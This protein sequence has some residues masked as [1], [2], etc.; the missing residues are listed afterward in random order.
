[1][2]LLLWVVACVPRHSPGAVCQTVPN[3]S[4][5]VPAHKPG[6]RVGHSL[7]YDDENQ[8]VLLIDGYQPPHTPLR[9]E[10]WAWDGARWRLAATAGPHSR[11]M[12]GVAYDSRRNRLIVYGGIATFSRSRYGDTWEWDG[13]AWQERAV[14]GPGPRDH[15]AMAFDSIRGKTVAYGGELRDGT[16][17]WPTDTWEW[18]GR[19]W[20]SFRAAGPN[21]RAHHAL[22]FDEKRGRVVLFGGLTEDRRYEGDTWEWDGSV[23]KRVATEGPPARTRHQMAFDRRRGVVVLYGGSGVRTKPGDGFN[24]LE[25]TWEW[26][27]R[28]WTE[29][30]AS[31]LGKRFMHAMAYDEKRGSVVLYG[32]SNGQQ[33]LDDTWILADGVWKRVG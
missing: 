9:G 3:R 7:V 31:G 26:D 18:D 28:K 25:D 22:A 30:A 5:A 2:L 13:R 8:R 20:V 21:G 11:T 1:M 33:N 12:S 23:W 19:E 24:V 6:A 17:A 32:G 15:H 10:I 16:R 14:A 27:G 4:H 29:V